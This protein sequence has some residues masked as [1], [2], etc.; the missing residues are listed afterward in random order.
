MTTLEQ[1]EDIKQDVEYEIGK[2]TILDENNGEILIKTKCF[3]YLVKKEKPSNKFIIEDI[4][5][6]F[7]KV[8]EKKKR[9]RYINNSR[10]KKENLTNG[11]KV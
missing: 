4:S 10:R 6:M 3:Y 2:F 8:L 9:Q 7:K 1:F 11:C 5:W